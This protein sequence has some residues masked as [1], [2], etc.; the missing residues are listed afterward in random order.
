MSG[1][2]SA[3]AITHDQL[4]GRAGRMQVGGADMRLAYDLSGPGSVS[5]AA[6]L[7]QP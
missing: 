6:V 5:A 4:V 1:F 2:G 3:V 7:S